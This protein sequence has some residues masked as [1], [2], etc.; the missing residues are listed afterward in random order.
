MLD[1]VDVLSFHDFSKPFGKNPC[2]PGHFHS[3][4]SFDDHLATGFVELWQ[5]H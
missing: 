4:L 3:I 5:E 1:A 2:F